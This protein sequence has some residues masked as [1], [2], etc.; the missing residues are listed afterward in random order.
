MG[1]AVSTT[2]RPM[3]AIAERITLISVSLGGVA[4]E[5]GPAHSDGA[6]FRASNHLSRQV[7]MVHIAC[8]Q[9]AGD[10]QDDEHQ[11]R[12]HLVELFP[13]FAGP[14]GPS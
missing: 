12:K 9:D 2:A 8:E 7:L 6:R 3:A 5:T 10:M 4:R 13:E 1:P 14:S 11:V